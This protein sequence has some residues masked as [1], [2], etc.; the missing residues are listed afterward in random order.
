MFFVLSDLRHNIV[1]CKPKKIFLLTTKVEHLLPRIQL[2]R[3]LDHAFPFLA[4]A[5]LPGIVRLLIELGNGET[6]QLIV[7]RNSHRFL[8]SVEIMQ[9]VEHQ[10][11]RGKVSRT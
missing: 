4:L 10:L 5:T 9:A 7:L 6:P 3:P 8:N 11:Q 1:Y 2:G